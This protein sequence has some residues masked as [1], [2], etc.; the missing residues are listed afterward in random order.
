MQ[1][2]PITVSSAVARN[3]MHVALRGGMGPRE[4]ER[5]TG[6][7]ELEASQADG[8]IA[9][10][11]HIA[12]L[13]LIEP[14]RLSGYA[15][16]SE[17]GSPLGSSISTLLGVITNAPTLADAIGKFLQLR[18]LIG[19]VDQL[20]CRYAGSDIEIEYVLEGSH[21]SAI[22]AFGNLLLLAKLAMQYSHGDRPCM[23]I[24]LTGQAFSCVRQLSELGRFQVTFGQTRNILRISTMQA[25]R[26]YL[27]HNPFS[28]AIL[29][30]QADADLAKLAQ[31]SSFA[32]QVEEQLRCALRAQ[33]ATHC[34]SPLEQLCEQLS[35]SR[36]ALHRRL[37]KETT[38]F[39]R[40]LSRAR[41]A[42]AT[43]LLADDKT[44]IAEI[45]D[46][47]GFSSPSAFSRFFTEQLGY[48][49]S[50]Y[51]RDGES[52]PGKIHVR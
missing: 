21:R 1:I 3:A 29:C 26:P 4:F 6:I 30:A 13:K 7:S 14:R 11:K 25:H 24:E 9:G 28:Y 48:P 22:S 20:L 35:I 50:R 17:P 27:L 44:G 49:P 32:R 23:Q 18:V 12:M 10:H 15:F 31:P 46:R 45:S 5:L 47:L 39:Q 8:R 33:T 43:L 40:I 52:W 16:H 51:R 38:N 2:L 37:Q 34:G 36:S 19:N 42:E 41:M